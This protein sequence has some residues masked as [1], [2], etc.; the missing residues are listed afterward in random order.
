MTNRRQRLGRK[1]EAI[2]ARHLEANGYGILQTNFRTRS[3][4]IDIVA[5]K[6]GVLVFVEV[7]TKSGRSFG[8]PEDSLTAVKRSRLVAV[9]E[10]YIQEA[11]AE[12]TEWRI[13]LCAL[14][15]NGRGALIR[16][17]VIENA[18]EL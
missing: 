9:A 10:E 6:D 7:R 12:N 2:A 15:M 14:E 13:D 17:D 1:G 3:G 18:V 8:T 16:L 5:R 11:G 4:E